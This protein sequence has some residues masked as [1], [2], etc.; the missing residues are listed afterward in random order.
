VPRS[1][2]PKDAFASTSPSP[3]GV[4]VSRSTPTR[5]RNLC[6]WKTVVSVGARFAPGA[7]PTPG[8]V[9]PAGS[10]GG[11]AAGAAAL[12]GAA[13]GAGGSGGGW[14]AG[15]VSV[16][17]SAIVSAKRVILGMLHIYRTG[18]FTP[19]HPARAVA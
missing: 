7:A 17:V 1:W 6:R 10:S 5:S 14:H 8:I 19:G 12:A 3:V 15:A 4:N 2:K 11:L 16:I 13:A 18:R 9:V